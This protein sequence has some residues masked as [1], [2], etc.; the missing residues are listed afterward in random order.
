MKYPDKQRILEAFGLGSYENARDISALHI[1]KASEENLTLKSADAV[2]DEYDDHE[3]H[4]AEHTRFLLS[5]EFKKLVRKE[6][7]KARFVEHIRQ[8]KKQA[9]LAVNTL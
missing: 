3:L 7:A 8:H 4:I 5:D 9:G 2:A 1:A 6:E